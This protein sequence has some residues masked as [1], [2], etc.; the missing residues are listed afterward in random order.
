MNHVDELISASLSGDLTD[1]ERHQLETHLES[2]ARCRATLAA[3]SDQRRLL[4]GMRHVAPPRDLGAR[5]RYGIES[6]RRT[7]L[8][9]WRRPTSML[10]AVGGLATVAAAIVL[11]VVLFD[12]PSQP[13]VAASTSPS[14]LA[15]V[16]ESATPLPSPSPSPTVVPSPTPSASASPIAVP[17][18]PAGHFVFRLENQAGSIHFVTPEEDMTLNLPALGTPATASL[19]ADGT[20]VAFRVDGDLSGRSD[21]YVLNLTDGSIVSLGE[22]LQPAY[23][24]GDELAWF[25]DEYLAYTL[26]TDAGQSDV[27]IYRASTGEVEQLTDTGNAFAASFFPTDAGSGIR[28][29]ISAA[30][31]QPVSYLVRLPSGGAAL[32]PAFDP[33]DQSLGTFPG[34]FEPLVSPDGFKVIY[35]RGAM[36][37]PGGHWSFVTGGMPYL[38]SSTDGPLD[39][40]DAQQLFSTLTPVRGESF[41]GAEIAWAPDS[42]AFAVWN[43]IWTGAPEGN[44]FPDP[45]R[46]YLGH[47]SAPELITA[48]Q[49]LDAADTK[50]A[51]GV[52][53]VALAGDGDHLALTLNIS[54]GAEGGSYGPTGQLRLVTRG[55]GSDP[56]KVE[57]LG[58]DKVWVGPAVYAGIGQP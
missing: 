53:D 17:T 27:W 9:W 13:P 40:E 19:S 44:G 23:G 16:A 6:G 15:S 42:D 46:V 33:A 31:D 51:E 41:K 52:V 32:P 39:F 2:C 49:A 20:M 57:I 58:Q 43:A 45:G 3:F 30:G 56:D 25:G 28:L 22:S 29:W 10:A 35:W 24:L 5:V 48:A 18:E 7:E 55:Y 50:D 11:A 4:S 37:T 54:E 36:G 14:T 26:T 1:A 34:V 21:S 12:N 8:P 38:D 47:V